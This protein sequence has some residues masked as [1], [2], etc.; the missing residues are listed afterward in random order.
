MGLNVSGQ[1]FPP[2]PKDLIAGLTVDV[3]G[4]G[5][6]VWLKVNTDGSLVTT[7]QNQIG[8]ADFSANPAT[9][10]IATFVLLTTVPATPNRAFVEVQNQSAA[11]I[12]LVR[13]DGTGGNPTTILMA[14]GGAAGTQGGG[15]SSSTFKGRVRIYG[16]S[17]AQVA[18]YQE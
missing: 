4:V 7:A 1:P 13:D 18:A 10:P 6:P 17:G 14:S 5:S 15:W 16:A 3:N 11:M 9:I 2:Y 12:Q 8:I